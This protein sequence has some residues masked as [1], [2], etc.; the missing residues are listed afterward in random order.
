MPV[1]RGGGLVL[2]QAQLQELPALD[3]VGEDHF[4]RPV[5]AGGGGLG[6]E[7]G[8][9]FA[10]HADHRVVGRDLER[11]VAQRCLAHVELEVG[12]DGAVGLAEL[13]GDDCGYTHLGLDLR[14]EQAVGIGRRRETVDEDLARLV[15]A[16]RLAGE[17]LGRELHH[18]G[19]IGHLEAHRAVVG[20]AHE[21]GVPYHTLGHEAQ[22]LR[23]DREAA[24]LG[25][26]AHRQLA[27]GFHRAAELHLEHAHV[28]AG[29]HFPAHEIGAFDADDLAGAFEAQAQRVELA[30]KDAQIDPRFLPQ[31][32][33]TEARIRGFG[34]GEE[35]RALGRLRL[36]FPGERRGAVG[37]EEPLPALRGGDGHDRLVGFET[38]AGGKTVELQRHHRA[39]GHCKVEHAPLA[40]LRHRGGEGQ[41]DGQQPFAL[42]DQL[43][44]GETAFR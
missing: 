13:V 40:L 30:L 43:V 15:G 8:H 35:Q 32:A 5:A 21:A 25:L 22:R 9:A 14:G 31:Q 19:D 23:A 29:Q 12:G 33:R 1:A 38:G 27:L 34:T 7:V 41:V 44:A 11:P 6:E 24:E 18:A 10:G 39:G 4:Q 37:R 28:L 3:G 16:E 42:G 17:L 2:F 26:A 36:V 20:H